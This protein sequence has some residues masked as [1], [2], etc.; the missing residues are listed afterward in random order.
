MTKRMDIKIHQN[1]FAARSSL[2]F[3][4][5]AGF[6]FKTVDTLV[7]PCSFLCNSGQFR[8]RQCHRIVASCDKSS[9]QSFRFAAAHI[10]AQA[11]RPLGRHIFAFMRPGQR[12]RRQ[13]HPAGRE[14]ISRLCHANKI[15][16]RTKTY[17]LEQANRALAD[18][19]AGGFEGAAVLIP[20]L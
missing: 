5:G 7:T 4:T 18:L 6:P 16:T 1:T 10:A 2:T 3:W 14:R 15:E 8:F 9:K 20:P 19:R 17:P 12:F 13:S 11:A